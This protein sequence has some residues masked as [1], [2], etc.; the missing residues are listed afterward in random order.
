MSN[1]RLFY[2]TFAVTAAMTELAEVFGVGTLW[3]GF[4]GVLFRYLLAFNNAAIVVAI[5]GDRK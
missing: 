5:W 2:L 3:P 1:F 4:A